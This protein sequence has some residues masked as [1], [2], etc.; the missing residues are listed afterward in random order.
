MLML[1]LMN[2]SHDLETILSV[3]PFLREKMLEGGKG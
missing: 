2:F 1:F 3:R